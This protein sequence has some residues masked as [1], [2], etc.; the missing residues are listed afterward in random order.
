MRTLSVTVLPKLC[1]VDHVWL[2]RNF[3]HF[4]VRSGGH[5]LTKKLKPLEANSHPHGNG[6]NTPLVNQS[7][8]LL[9]SLQDVHWLRTGSVGAPVALLTHADGVTAL[10]TAP[11][12]TVA[13]RWTGGLAPL[14]CA[15]AIFG[16]PNGPVV[17]FSY[18]SRSP[19]LSRTVGLLRVS[20]R[21]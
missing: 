21:Q 12:L 1:P 14:Q 6:P 10:L 7:T 16:V 19:E 17:A 13:W 18:A 9:M 15:V 3:S 5:F 4:S 8:L 2:S 11:T 20:S